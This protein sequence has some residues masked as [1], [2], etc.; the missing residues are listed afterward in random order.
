MVRSNALASCCRVLVVKGFGG[1]RFCWRLSTDETSH[2]VVL[3]SRA[4]VRAPASVASSRIGACPAALDC[5][6]PS[7]LK[8]R[9]S[10]TRLPGVG[11]QSVYGAARAELGYPSS[12][13]AAQ[14]ANR[15]GIFNFVL[16]G[17][18]GSV[19]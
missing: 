9:P 11:G 18:V 2:L 13:R 17:L 10:A 5:I 15:C 16:P 4:A 6:T 19:R 1:F 14:M 12:V 7:E 3:C 8:S